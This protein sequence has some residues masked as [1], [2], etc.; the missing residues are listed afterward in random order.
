MGSSICKL[1]TNKYASAFWIDRLIVRVALRDSK[2]LPRLVYGSLIVLSDDETAS[3]DEPADR[4]RM[5][6]LSLCRSRLQI[7]GFY[8]RVPVSSKFCLKFDF[9]H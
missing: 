5:S 1:A 7:L 4:E 3:E 8:F 6:V 9:A 2:D